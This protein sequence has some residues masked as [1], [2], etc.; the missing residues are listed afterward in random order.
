MA[1]VEGVNARRAASRGPAAHAGLNV[2]SSPSTLTSIFDQNTRQCTRRSLL[3]TNEPHKGGCLRRKCSS[4]SVPIPPDRLP[5]TS[6]G[7]PSR[8]PPPCGH[9]ESSVRASSK[10]TAPSSPPLRGQ[11][12]PR[13]RSAVKRG[14]LLAA[15]GPGAARHPHPPAPIPTAPRL[16]GR[17]TRADS[18]ATVASAITDCISAVLSSAAGPPRPRRAHR[19][20]DQ[21]V[22]VLE[23][24][25]CVTEGPSPRACATQGGQ[26]APSLCRLFGQDINR[27]RD[28]SSA[29][30]Q[31]RLRR[32]LRF[33]IAGSNRRFKLPGSGSGRARARFAVSTPS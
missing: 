32:M 30:L 20:D 3:R 2:R 12:P 21:I 8:A 22:V 9:P 33:G 19:H 23:R 11:G 25:R 1:F 7:P 27:A 31:M 6:S 15:R 14:W 17:G 24:A 18:S 13:A 28:D 29:S 4:D 10:G 26:L 16:P 5:R